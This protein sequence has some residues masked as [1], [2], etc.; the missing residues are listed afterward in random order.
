MGFIREKHRA[1]YGAKEGHL[2]KNSMWM[3]GGT[4]SC[5]MCSFNAIE[6][7]VLIIK[8]IRINI[9]LGSVHV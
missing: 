2:A 5:C 9:N 8:P 4:Q 6:L 1:I 3:G 7:R